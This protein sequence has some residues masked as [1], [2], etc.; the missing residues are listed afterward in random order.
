MKTTKSIKSSEFAKSIILPTVDPAPSSVKGKKEKFTPPLVRGGYA[1]KLASLVGYH[2]S[3]YVM[4]A[5]ATLRRD[6]LFGSTEPLAVVSIK[7]IFREHSMQWTR[8]S[9]ICSLSNKPPFDVVPERLKG[10]TDPETYYEGGSQGDTDVDL[11]EGGFVSQEVIAV[12]LAEGGGGSPE[13]IALDLVEGGGG[14]QEVFDVEIVKSTPSPN[15]VVPQSV[16]SNLASQFTG[17]EDSISGLHLNM[18]DMAVISCTPETDVE[19]IL[20]HASPSQGYQSSL[21]GSVVNAI[22]EENEVPKPFLNLKSSQGSDDEFEERTPIRSNDQSGVQAPLVVL[23][24]PVGVIRLQ[25]L[26]KEIGYSDYDEGKLSRRQDTQDDIERA[27]SVTTSTPNRFLS[28]GD[29]PAS[30]I[31]SIDDRTWSGTSAQVVICTPVEELLSQDH[32]MPTQESITPFEQRG[33]VE[34]EAN[35]IIAFSNLFNW[36]TLKASD[37][38]EIHEPCRHVDIPMVGSDACVKKVWIAERYKIVSAP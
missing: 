3:E 7:E 19:I 14:S 22:R 9:V 10:R 8:C 20:E 12:D 34:S 18:G 21:D 25:C 24:E 35:F 32:H 36:S 30:V 11:G 15:I 16:E 1:E 37:L 27:T 23:P 26:D 5:N 4:W 28:D 29:A 2:K 31:S 17:E 33:N 6:K 13:V 38:V